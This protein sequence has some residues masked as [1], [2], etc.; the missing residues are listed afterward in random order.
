FSR[1]YA[2]LLFLQKLIETFYP[3]FFQHGYQFG[4]RSIACRELFPI[5]IPQCTDQ[6]IT[7]FFANLAIPVSYP[8]VESFRKMLL[9]HIWLSF[10]FIASLYRNQCPMLAGTSPS[11]L[12]PVLDLLPDAQL[13]FAGSCCPCS[14]LPRT[15]RCRICGA[16]ISLL[17]KPVIDFCSINLIFGPSISPSNSVIRYAV[18]RLTL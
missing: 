10:V 8:I 7:P 2:K 11:P 6:S 1:C 3:F 17:R 15:I 13:C 16:E 12:P 18:V 5:F 4:V 9:C 14:I